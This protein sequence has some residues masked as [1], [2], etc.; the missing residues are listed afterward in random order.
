MIGH[1]HSVRSVKIFITKYL[2]FHKAMVRNRKKQ[3]AR[4]PALIGFLASLA[5]GEGW[6]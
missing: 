6:G 5:G 1:T 4:G 3:K 2:H